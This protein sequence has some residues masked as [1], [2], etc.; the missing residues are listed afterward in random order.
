VGTI[1]RLDPHHDFG[2]DRV[3]A[4]V[5]VLLSIVISWVLVLIGSQPWAQH[6]TA[7]LLGGTQDQLADPNSWRVQLFVVVFLT[8][9]MMLFGIVIGFF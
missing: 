5:L 1:S 3:N 8:F 4:I 9:I 2:L 6:T 7:W